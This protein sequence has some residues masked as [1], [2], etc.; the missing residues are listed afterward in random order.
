[1]RWSTTENIRWKTAIPGEGA[2]SPIVGGE[3]VFVTSAQDRG[4]RRLVHCLD[5]ESGQLCWSREIKHE[6]PETASAVTGHAAATPATDG[7]RVVAFFGNAGAVCY[8]FEG[9]PLWRRDLGQFDSE[10]G[11]ASSPI[12]HEGKVIL[13]CDHDGTRFTSFDSFL[14]AVDCKTGETVWKTERHGLERSWSTPVVVPGL[15]GKPELIVSAQE[16]VRAYDPQ[17]GKELWR[18]AGLTGWVAPSP[19]FGLGLI[20]GTSGKNGPVLAVRPGGRGDVTVTHVA[21]KHENL[22]PYV[23]SPLLH[24]DYL[25]VH[26]ELGILTCFEAKTGKAQ[27]RERLEGKF[28]SSGVAGDGKVYLFNEA[29]AGFVIRTGPRFELLAK[30]AL[31][32]YTVASPAIAHGCLFVRTQKHLWCVRQDGKRP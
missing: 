15:N 13:I 9:K 31:S 21:W 30:N 8:D 29:G 4:V 14:I 11:L 12:I 19:V 23:C 2:S 32:E 28:T 24:G 17:N 27:Y 5:R 16:H 18:V 1:V 3:R 25:Y 20:F 6:N 22:G 10:L 7:Q 26:N